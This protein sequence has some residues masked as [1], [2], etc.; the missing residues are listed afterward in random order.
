MDP[1]SIIASIAGIASAGAQ[2]SN[3]LF[4]L[5]KTVRNAPKEIQ[6]V[7][8][9]ISGL[10]VTLEHLCDIIRTG[11]SY[12]KPQFCDAVRHVVKNIQ[13]TQQEVSE[14]ATD[15]SVLR[16]V[17]WR[18][19]ARLLSDIDKH[20]VTLTLQITILSAAVL[21]KST[22]GRLP[23]QEKVEN[24]FK[25]QAE[26]LILAGQASLQNDE[27]EPIPDP[28]QERAPSPPVRTSKRLPSPVRES[29]IPGHVRT[30]EFYGQN[31][32]S[33][34]N[35]FLSAS[36]K[37]EV[38][39]ALALSVKDPIRPER[40]YTVPAIDD[41]DEGRISSEDE[42]R[43]YRR[44]R[45]SGFDPL[46]GGSIAQFGPDFHR[47]GDAATF[48]YNLVF[49][50]EIPVK[51]APDQSSYMRDTGSDEKI[52]VRYQHRHSDD[53]DDSEHNGGRRER[54][55]FR[56]PK[57]QEPGRIV[58]RLLLA[59]TSLSKSEVE[60]GKADNQP[61]KSRAFG[62]SDSS[63]SE[64]SL[65]GPE[66]PEKTWRKETRTA[67]NRFLRE[68]IKYNNLPEFD[69]RGRRILRPAR[70]RTPTLGY[71]NAPPRN[72]GPSPASEEPTMPYKNDGYGQTWGEV[73]FSHVP[74]NESPD[75]SNWMPGASNPTHRYSFPPPT[76]S[77]NP[78]T[79]TKS[80]RTKLQ[81]PDFVVLPQADP[82]DCEA[83]PMTPKLDLTSVSLGIMRQGDE[84]IW[85][86]DAFMSEKGFRGKAIMGTLIGDKSARNPHGLD[87]AHTLMKGRSMKLVYI[88]GNDLG[89]TWFINEQPIFL[90]FLHS[91]YLPQFYPAKETDER[92]MKEEYVAIGEEWA[93]F[94]A[95]QQLGLIVKRREEGR[96]LL[97]PSTTWSMIKELATTTLQLRSMRQ[98]RTF[99]ST[100]YKP[101]SVF[102]Q[103]HGVEVLPLV[104]TMESK[105]QDSAVPD[106][107]ATV[108]DESEVD[109]ID[110]PI[111]EE[112]K[113]T[114]ESTAEAQSETGPVAL[115]PQISIT[116]PST[117]QQTSPDYLD[118]SEVA[119]HVSSGSR[120]SRFVRRYKLGGKKD[121]SL[122]LHR[123]S[124]K[125]SGHAN[126]IT[127]WQD[128]DKRPLTP[129]D[130]GVG[131]SIVSGR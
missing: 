85:D 119:S 10:T 123:Q 121:L 9:E 40:R 71:T 127:E 50:N 35:A 95:L 104:A 107:R 39:S 108:E 47:R 6:S 80:A 11:Q 79:G 122:P 77:H 20:K 116:P 16:R 65:Y 125:I 18:K 68:D 54:V 51:G 38:H 102:R 14:M 43:V 60:K 109:I 126:E 26:S 22:S 70:S 72:N 1:L 49:L 131:S 91:G 117:P 17:K 33:E 36:E 19:A 42:V 114:P 124:S 98:R 44:R 56:D 81:K 4:R 64:E 28:P 94:E 89:E 88:R 83:G 115:Q 3:T 78:A 31:K 15:E 8:I 99:T 101:I 24:R 93:S 76:Q 112:P 2:L 73:Q 110:L 46:S 100:F 87:L 67:R 53:S 30:E 84:P 82:A 5:Y 7:A 75:Q 21:V 13:V 45:R 59:W 41:K 61:D 32:N 69:P 130:S 25:A 103:K 63:D 12:A 120:L 23:I 90:Q 48:L 55:R 118:T 62:E 52:E 105:T 111:N 128:D 97:E 58:N 74:T 92:A 37:E 113:K 106:R 129:T 86:C 57:P 27:S 66:D 34:D 96:V 29:E